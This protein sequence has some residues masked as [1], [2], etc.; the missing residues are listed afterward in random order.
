[1]MTEIETLVALVREYRA[2]IDGAEGSRAH[3]LLRRC[4]TL[5]P[6]IYAAG[7]ALPEVEPETEGVD[8][9]QIESPLR[10]LG[11]LL[12]RYDSYLEIFDPYQEDDSVRGLVSDDLA[13][14]YLDLVEPL[15]A[16]EAGRV[17][18][19]VWSWRVSIRGHCGDHIVDAMRA[20]HRLIH[21]HMP[22][23]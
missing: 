16:F 5:L 3:T 15:A 9:P 7:L 6:R 18:D 4:A 22:E 13:D 2:V 1:M 10:L 14:S 17:H 23:D 21:V 8:A 19:A 11:A 12:G 20:I